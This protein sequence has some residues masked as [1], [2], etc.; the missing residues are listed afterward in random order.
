M[1]RRTLALHCS[2]EKKEEE[3]NPL[4]FVKL[5]S[6]WLEGVPSKTL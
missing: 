1:E 5:S 4:L 3:K 6:W 2:N